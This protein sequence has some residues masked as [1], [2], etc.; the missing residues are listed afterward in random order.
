MPDLARRVGLGLNAR[1]DVADTVAWAE[2]ARSAG[3][4]SI[5]FH[6]SYF[7]RDAVTYASATAAQVADIKIGLGAL[8]PFTRHPVLIAM[9]IS[10]LDEMAPERILLGLG[11]ALPLRLA[12]MGIPYTP[13]D[14]VTK[15]S[16]AMDVL[17][18]L[19]KGER[20]PSGVPG[21][22]PLQPMFP[23]VHRVPIYIA[24]YRSPM[25]A[26]AGQKGDGYLARP[27]ES[28]PGLKKLLSVMNKA[29]RDAGRDPKDLDVAGYLLSLVADTRRDALNRAKREPFVIFMMSILSDVTLNRAGFDPAL[30]DR[31]AVYW[32]KEDYTTAGGLIPDELLDAFILCGT[33]REIADRA[34][35]YHEAGMDLPILQPVVQDEDQVAAVLDAAVAYGS[36]EAGA[37]GTRVA[38]GAQRKTAVAGFRDRVSAY[39][40]ISRPFSF[41]A[42]TV[43]VAVGGALAAVEGRFDWTL[44]LVSLIAGVLIHVGTNITNEIYDVRKGVDTI[45]SPRASHAIVTGRITD[46][47]AYVLAI[48]AFAI[49]FAL[50]LYL[51]SVRGWPVVA[52]GLIALIGGYT[53]TAPPFQYK[54]SPF[55]LPLVFILMGPLMVVGSYYVITGTIGWSALAISIPVGLLVAAILHGNEWR[56]ISEDARA[57]ARTFSVR[58]G[59]QAAHWLYLALV[60]GAYLALTVAVVGEL[61]PTWTLLAMLSLPLLVRQIRSAEFGASGQ[62]RAIAMIDLQTAQLHAAFGYLMVIGLLV[63]ALAA[64]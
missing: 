26:L 9:T 23:P 4:E 43:P 11:S 7:E 39:W 50:G 42:S 20:I 51:V 17:H 14:A 59:R 15:S 53:Y 55:G 16:E 61:L 56:D 45:V 3:L 10:A 8:N 32:R 58:M 2:R 36:G 35:E 52:L 44:F 57:G 13:P 21:L 25:M 6:D 48:S 12:Q 37:V 34:W 41:T 33:R 19:W 63:A 30:R 18:T 62:Q 49:A 29:A 24:G 31:I 38:L 27:A 5:W 1:G 64:R 46:R 28:I 60:V 40:E 22:P 54:F 47:E